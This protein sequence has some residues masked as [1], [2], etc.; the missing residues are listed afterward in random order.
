[1]PENRLAID[2]YNRIATQFNYDFR[3]T[4]LIVQTMLHGMTFSQQEAIELIDKL[5]AIRDITREHEKE[6]NGG[7]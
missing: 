6:D 5:I 2:L 1:M 4:E 7:Q 3:C